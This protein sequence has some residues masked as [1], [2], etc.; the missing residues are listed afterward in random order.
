MPRGLEQR[1]LGDVRRVDELEALVD[2]PL[3]SVVLHLSADDPALRVEHRQARAEHLRK[4]EQVKLDPQLAVV[5]LGGLGQPGLVRLEGL[6]ARP[7]R[8]VETLQRGVLLVAAP[9]SGGVASQ[10]EGR[11]VAGVRHVRAAA[12]VLP[13]GRAVATQV[14]V[15]GQLAGTDLGTGPLVV[16]RRALVGDQLELVRLVGQLGSS[17]LVTHQASAEALPLLDDRAHA[18]LQLLEVLR[19]ERLGHVEVVVEAVGDRRADAEPGLLVTDLYGLGRDMRGRVAQDR[20]PFGAVDGD[21]LDFRVRRDLPVQVAGLA[22]D[23]DGDDGPVVTKQIES[24]GRTAGHQ[25]GAYAAVTEGDRHG[26]HAGKTRPGPPGA[27]SSFA[28]V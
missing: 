9:V 28:V 20:Q 27:H 26:R 4:A 13:R 10:R 17:L 5:A 15:D 22:I 25:F 11:D 1:T 14:V 6:P 2:V 16:A 3:A 18:L 21:L 19:S 8:A 12:Q 7:G 23:P 24:G